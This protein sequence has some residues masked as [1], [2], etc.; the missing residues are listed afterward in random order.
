MTQDELTKI[1]DAFYDSDECT[2]MLNSAVIDLGKNISR[3]YT[4]ETI[5]EAVAKAFESVSKAIIQMQRGKQ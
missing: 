4:E 1:F 3:T 2:A 5:L